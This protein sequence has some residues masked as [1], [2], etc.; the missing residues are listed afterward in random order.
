ML[1]YVGVEHPRGAFS[2]HLSQIKVKKKIR[3]KCSEANLV[4][5][6]NGAVRCC[7]CDT[8]FYPLVA[9]G[10]GGIV[11][12]GGKK[13]NVS[14]SEVLNRER[15]RIKVMYTTHPDNQDHTL[16]CDVGSPSVSNGNRKEGIFYLILF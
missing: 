14:V 13:I 3:K 12:R 11:V 2:A 4:H 16:E 15:T 5:L 10:H 7:G 6:R 1:N 9:R 8:V